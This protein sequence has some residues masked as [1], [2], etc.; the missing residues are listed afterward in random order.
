MI[1]RVFNIFGPLVLAIFL[2]GGWIMLTP[3]NPNKYSFKNEQKS[4]TALTAEVF[5]NKTLKEQ[6]FRDPKHK[7]IPFF[8]SSEWS[9]MDALHPAVLAEKYNR[10]YRPFLL[11]Q[12]GAQSLTHFLGMQQIKGAIYQKKAVYVISPQWFTKQ[13][14]SPLAIKHYI[15]KAQVLT[16]LLSA[17]NSHS[18]KY[19]AQ[20]LMAMNMNSEYSKYFNKIVDGRPLST[21]DT[22]S[23]KLQLNILMHEDA[24][25]AKMQTTDKYHTKIVPKLNEL[26]NHYDEQKL[27]TIACELA[28]SKT[29]NNKF[30][31][32][33]NFYTHRILPKLSKLKNSQKHFDY[34]HSPEYGDLELALNQF[35][36]SKT[37]VLFVFPPVNKKWAAYSGLDLGMY[38]RAINKI[39]FQLKSQGFNNIADFSK[40]GQQKYFMEDTIHVGWKGWLAYDNQIKSFVTSPVHKNKYHINDYFFSK[41]WSNQNY[42]K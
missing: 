2:I 32:E 13:G 8:G 6:A 21:F 12:R 31:I 41:A 40:D 9:R 19:L 29:N 16:W 18:D 15:S 7:F 26:P 27:N 28:K 22:N 14:A 42:S 39:R 11:G 3:I 23:I 34:T 24:F 38:Q 5:K 20:R 10:S 30:N 36:A 4:A 37:D 1:R 17:K 33:N 25:F 35:A